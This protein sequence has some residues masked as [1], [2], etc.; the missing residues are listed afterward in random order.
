MRLQKAHDLMELD[1]LLTTKNVLQ[2]TAQVNKTSII[3]I[4]KS[5]LLDVLPEGSH[6]SGTSFLANTEH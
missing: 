2:L 1:L 3:R 4:L 5:I 6:N